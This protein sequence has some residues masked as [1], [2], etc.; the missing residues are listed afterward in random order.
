MQELKDPYHVKLMPLEECK[1]LASNLRAT[2][3]QVTSENG[4][5]LSSNLGVVE[6]TIALY[7]NFDF[8]NDKLL[9]DVGHQCYTHK[10]LSGRSLDS[11]R[12]K[13]G[14][15]GFQKRAE[16]PYDCFEAGHSS[17]SLSTALGMACARDLNGEKYHIVSLIGDASI[18]SGEA[19]EAL[20]AIGHCHHKVIIVLN[21]NEMSISKP[22]GSISKLFSKIRI[23]FGYNRAKGRYQRFL[24]KTR[25]GYRFYCMTANVKN[26]FKRLVIPMN[27]FDNLGIDYIGPIDG[28]DL[29]ALDKAFNKAK[30]NHASCLIHCH[31]I[32]GK[33]YSFAEKDSEGKWHGVGPFHLEDGTPKKKVDTPSWSKF[34]S[35]LVD[36]QMEK[37]ER[38]VY[39]NPAMIRGSE[40]DGIFLH[41]P[42]RAIDTGIAEEHAISFA[43]GIALS[44]KHPI[45]AIYSTFLQ[46]G[47]DQINQDLCRMD[48]P[49]T[50]LID[51]SGVVG[52][53]GETHQGI[54]DESFLVTTPNMI[55]SMAGN[56]A[57][58]QQLF[59]L[60]THAKH[61][62]AIRFPRECEF[63]SEE[64]EENDLMIGKWAW[65]MRANHQKIC[66]GIGP[67][68]LQLYQAAHKENLDFDFLQA[69]FMKPM[70]EEAL[71]TLL[72]YQE[73]YLYQPYATRYGWVQ[74]V[75]SYL[76]EHHYQGQVFVHCL[77]DAFI[78]QATISEQLSDYSLTVDQ[79]LKILQ[80]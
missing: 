65:K 61:P 24:S 41:H 25:I 4:G 13:G 57:Q 40:A 34:Y 72:V 11:L 29:K 54:Y 64:K 30:R 79:M 69:I 53:D 35:D 52:A 66:V 68:F 70:D 17:T 36:Q 77:P 56:V 33:G 12:K 74:S 7:R 6:L 37:D 19:F 27:Y 80:K 49:C 55:V 58:A 47:F 18:V 45:I 51:R 43:S 62:F 44:G 21:D 75:L 8:P 38:L 60:S 28:H 1:Q 67:L 73:I 26:S 5:H 50:L 39:I 10:L 2:I 3:L 48:L 78:K 71:S 63:L 14:I 22:V 20:N 59:D 31:T 76:L 15:S 32:K 23:S 42:T 46:R 9:F 16:S